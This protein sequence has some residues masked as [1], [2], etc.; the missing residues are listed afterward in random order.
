MHRV[1]RHPNL[2]IIGFMHYWI[3]H[4]LHEIDSLMLTTNQIMYQV[5]SEMQRELIHPHSSGLQAE[6]W[7]GVPL[8]GLVPLQQSRYWLSLRT[9]LRPGSRHTRGLCWHHGSCYR[10]NRVQ[11]SRK[12]PRRCWYTY[13]C[14]HDPRAESAREIAD[15]RVYTIY[16]GAVNWDRAEEFEKQTS[17]KKSNPLQPGKN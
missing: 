9:R 1:R 3:R 7:P 14:T 8:Y 15:I 6:I 2:C 4:V 10:Q 12:Y 13:C 11:W 17:R 16:N 5:L